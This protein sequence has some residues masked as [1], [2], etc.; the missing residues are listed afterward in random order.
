MASAVGAVVFAFSLSETNSAQ[1]P[2][3]AKA[4]A[5]PWGA[6]TIDGWS[7][8]AAAGPPKAKGPDRGGLSPRP[9]S[10]T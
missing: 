2:A 5:Q 4:A 3:L 6:W 8:G 10:P 1:A 7:P 9:A